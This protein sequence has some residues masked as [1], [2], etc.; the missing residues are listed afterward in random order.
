MTELLFAYGTLKADFALHYVIQGCTYVGNYKT[1]AAFKLVD[2][3]AFPALVRS[4]K[5][6][7]VT[8]EVYRVDDDILNYLDVI[9]GVNRGLYTRERVIVHDQKGDT[10][11]VWAYIANH[12]GRLS[13]VE[14]KSGV[15]RR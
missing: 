15:W 9:E 5:G 11:D 7:E 2:L 8:G 12:V 1:P 10:I 14:I 3:G 4:E 6:I 13:G